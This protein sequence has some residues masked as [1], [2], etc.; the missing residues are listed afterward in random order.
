[1]KHSPTTRP[2]PAPAKRR[3]PNS[4]ARS[5]DAKLDEHVAFLCSFLRGPASVGAVAPS[6][7]A[8]ALAM[9][10]GCD[11]AHADTVVELGPGTGA[12]T[13]PIC[14]EIGSRTTFIAL[15]LDAHHVKRLQRQFPRAAVY[16][17]NAALLPHYLARHEKQKADYIISG[18]PWASIPSRERERIMTAILASLAPGGVFIT[19]GY[20][21]ARL[22]PGARRFIAQLRQDFLRVERSK[23]VWRNIPP[24]YVYR[25]TLAGPSRS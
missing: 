11:L 9:L 24:A 10:T 22:L 13:G 16:H 18:L 1:M 17:D 8:L 6:S 7:P 3:R 4:P 15:E 5:L 21:H 14:D 20:F 23:L 12:F 2:R 19:F 25:C